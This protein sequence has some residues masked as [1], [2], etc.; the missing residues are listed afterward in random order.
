MDPCIKSELKIISGPLSKVCNTHHA[1]FIARSCNVQIRASTR[2]ALGEP[3]AMLLPVP[4]TG[5]TVHGGVGK[6]AWVLDG[7]RIPGRSVRCASK[8]T[9]REKTISLIGAVAIRMLLAT[10]RQKKH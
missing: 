4:R 2:E 3:E 9:L 8:K 5:G 7:T 10:A 1:C 6:R